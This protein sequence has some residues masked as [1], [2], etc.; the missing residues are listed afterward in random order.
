MQG[1]RTLIV[2]GLQFLL[3]ILASLGIVVPDGVTPDTLAGAVLM[4][5]GVVMAV[6]RVL[7]T[8]PVTT[9]DPQ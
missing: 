4:I 7:T 6:L 5:S 9:K 3:G 8:T 2:A 1:Y